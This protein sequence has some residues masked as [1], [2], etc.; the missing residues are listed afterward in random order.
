MEP[1]HL[2]L[3]YSTPML[4]RNTVEITVD[5]T[6]KSKHVSSVLSFEFGVLSSEFHLTF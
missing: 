4:R 1:Q 6:D 2:F 3:V 5:S